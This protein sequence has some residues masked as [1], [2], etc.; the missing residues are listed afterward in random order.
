M[1]TWMP[2]TLNKSGFSLIELMV[3]I[4]LIGLM[5]TIGFPSYRAL[6]PGAD[7]KKFLVQLDR[8]TSFAWRNAQETGKI[9]SILFDDKNHLVHVQIDSGQR[10]SS[11]KIILQPVKRAYLNTSIAIPKNLQ[12]KNFIIEGYDEA[13]KGK[14]ETAYFYI[15]PNG[16]TQHVTINMNDVKD[17]VGTGRARQISLVLNPFTARFK[18]YDAFQK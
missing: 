6:F 10:D 4:A 13:S 12:I 3:V 1:S 15:M 5:A 18:E 16:L 8:L 14:L 2:G 7:R 9:Q 11:G 17:K